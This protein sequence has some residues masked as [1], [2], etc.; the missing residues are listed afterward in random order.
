MD[1]AC[2]AVFVGDGSL[3]IQCAQ[4]WR[5]RGN[6]IVAV[7]SHNPAILEWATG[8]GLSALP[9][10]GQPA[11]LGGAGFDYL[12]SIANLQMLPAEL[13]ESPRALAINF[14]DGP[15]PRYA[16]LNA[17]SWALAARETSHGVTWHEMTA[18]A[19]AG[20]IVRQAQFPIVPGDT[21]LGL[22]AR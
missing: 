17:T 3:L 21:A 22:N 12:F 6:A 13:V 9:V 20:R 19:D 1:Y 14:H 4:A 2:A 10:E 8:Q 18:V 15:L 16:G 5:Q 11:G 7:L